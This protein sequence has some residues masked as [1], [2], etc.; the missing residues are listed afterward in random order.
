MR[1]QPTFLPYLYAKLAKLGLGRNP[2][3]RLHKEVNKQRKKVSKEERL[4]DGKLI[5]EA[6]RPD[7][8]TN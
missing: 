2:G 8:M 3:I 1:D 4:D 5:E 7:S 6:S